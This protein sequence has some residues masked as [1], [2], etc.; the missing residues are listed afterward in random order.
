MQKAKVMI[1]DDSFENVELLTTVLSDRGYEVVVAFDGE[2]ALVKAREETPDLLLLD[3][4]MPKI[5][6]YEVCRQLKADSKTKRIPILMLSARGAIPDRVK[7]LDLGA[8]DYFTKPFNIKELMA[9]V[10]ARL[11][12]KHREDDLL[13]TEKRVRD[14]FQ[15][16]VSTR[17]VERLLC[18]PKRVELGGLK[19]EVT[20]LFADLR[21]FTALAEHLPPERLIGVLNGYL[22]AGAQPIL[23]HDG[24]INQYA[25]DEIMAIFNAPL[26]QEDHVLRAVKAGL[27][28]HERLRVYNATLEPDLRL[29]CGVGIGTGQAVVGNVGTSQIM[30]YTAVGD[31]VNLAKR[32]EESA[33]GGEVLIGESSYQHVKHQVQVQS[34]PPLTVKGREK[35]VAVYKVLELKPQ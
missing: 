32:L 16:Y 30:N 4:M 21:G 7:G 29:N 22:S 6:G 11:R 35:L 18:N 14:T 3:I 1:A 26:H 19:Q 25:G 13:D 5:D 17:V 8:E 31:V 10:Q 28:I 33:K 23:D 20:V 27:V 15:R 12:A 9:R 24:T 2:E 34:L